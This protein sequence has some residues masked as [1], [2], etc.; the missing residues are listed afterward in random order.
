MFFALTGISVLI[1][2]LLT[3]AYK[4][5]ETARGCLFIYPY[6]LLLWTDGQRENLSKFTFLALT[7]TAVMQLIGNYFW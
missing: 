3:G 7:Q 5:G 2:V 6:L 1:A 4:T